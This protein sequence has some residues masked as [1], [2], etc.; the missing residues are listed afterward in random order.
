ME[1]AKNGDAKYVYAVIPRGTARDMQSGIHAI[2]YRDIE[3]L[4][5]DC[6]PRREGI[7]EVQ[8]GD[9]LKHLASSYSEVVETAWAEVGTVLPAGFDFVI[10]ADDTG[11]AEAKVRRWLKK[12]Y[13]DFKAKLEEL[14]NR[15]E[16]GV[17]IIW[18]TAAAAQSITTE[19]EEVRRLQAQAEGKSKRMARIYH[20]KLVAVTARK[21]EER[22]TSDFAGFYRRLKPH[23]E[24]ARV[25]SVSRDPAG[26]MMVSLALL[27]RLD[28]VQALGK[29]LERLGGEPRV[30]V[31]LI[32][33]LPPYTFS[34][35]IATSGRHK[36]L[37]SRKRLRR[38]A[39]ELKGHR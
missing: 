3:A 16:L 38:R 12:G 9:A 10:R 31:R 22:A 1:M 15:V 14:R 7:L 8:D 11:S 37:F 17:C 26:Q 21:I 18:D 35:Q 30:A 5:C 36:A 4:V 25:N 19:D 24:G 13:G 27:V 39:L 33:P 32:G 2:P 20:R 23:I 29:E 34:A 28:Q 6:T